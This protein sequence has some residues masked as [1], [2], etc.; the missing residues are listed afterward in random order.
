ML[1]DRPRLRVVLPVSRRAGAR[2]ARPAGVKNPKSVS[3]I[4]VA[5]ERRVATL[6]AEAVRDAV[7]VQ[8][9]VA[10]DVR[11]RSLRSG[12]IRT[13]IVIRARRGTE[14][15]EPVGT[16]L[17]LQGVGAV[18]RWQT[19]TLAPSIAGL[20]RILNAVV[21]RVVE[22]D[23]AHAARRARPVCADAGAASDRR[24]RQERRGERRR[25]MCFSGPC[26][27]CCVFSCSSV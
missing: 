22:D 9:V 14:E 23:A 5:D 16:G 26:S 19:N 4:A 27:S 11:R 7:A 18:D 3:Q 25:P 10:A 15:V 24:Q 2:V 21:V 12:G 17:G 20:A 13:A 8:G 6:Y 1:A